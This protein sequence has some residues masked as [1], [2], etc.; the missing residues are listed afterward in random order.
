[1][2]RKELL[3]A[4]LLSVTV[5]CV[6][7]NCGSKC[8]FIRKSVYTKQAGSNSSKHNIR[9][10]TKDAA[11]LSQ[12]LTGRNALQFLTKLNLRQIARKLKGAA[13]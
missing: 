12:S 4:H 13:H 9:G 8:S 11:C 2:D 6:T 10:K 3:R 7:A 5:M 1:M